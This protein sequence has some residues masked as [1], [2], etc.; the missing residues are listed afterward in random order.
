MTLD[1]GV[2]RA[3]AL[4]KSMERAVHDLG[5]W[6][7]ERSGL[8]VPAVRVIASDRVIFRAEFPDVCW[9]DDESAVLF[10]KSRGEYVI[11]MEREHFDGAHMIEWALALPEALAVVA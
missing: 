7:M 10:L 11:S 6:T 2:A 1:L 5:P 8:S 4:A 9:L 3:V